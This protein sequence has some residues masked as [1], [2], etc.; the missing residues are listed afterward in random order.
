LRTETGEVMVPL[1]SL[2]EWDREWVEEQ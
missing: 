1:D 2:S